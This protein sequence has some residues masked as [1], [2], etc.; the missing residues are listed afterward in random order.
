MHTPSLV[1]HFGETSFNH[2]RGRDWHPW[3]HLLDNSNGDIATG[4]RQASS[5]M[6]TNFEE[7]A[8]DGM[9]DQDSCLVA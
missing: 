2:A 8:I 9:Y 5:Q 1:N 7:V 4:L 3:K 6:K